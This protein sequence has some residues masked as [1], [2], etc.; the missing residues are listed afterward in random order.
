MDMQDKGGIIH[1]CCFADML[2][3]EN[4]L[5][6]GFDQIHNMYNPVVYETGDILDTMIYRLGLENAKY[7]PVT[8]MPAAV[9]K[10]Y[11]HFLFQRLFCGC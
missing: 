11:R 1:D 5:N 7:D 2:S 3:L 8:D 4:V 9:Y 10:R 6:V